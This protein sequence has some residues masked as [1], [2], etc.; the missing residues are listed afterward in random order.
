MGEGQGFV[1]V[2]EREV[3]SECNQNSLY[4]RDLSKSKLQKH[5]IN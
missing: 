4:T 3:E 1:E 5:K 2:G